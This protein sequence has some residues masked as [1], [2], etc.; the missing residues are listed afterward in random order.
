MVNGAFS[1]AD[2]LINDLDRPSKFYFMIM[3]NQYLLN[4]YNGLFNIL[5]ILLYISIRECNKINIKTL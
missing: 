3:F 1:E 5:P 4:L 2:E